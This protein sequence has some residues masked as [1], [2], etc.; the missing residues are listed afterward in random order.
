MTQQLLKAGS[1]F[2]FE[3]DLYQDTGYLFTS[4]DLGMVAILVL[5]KDWEGWLDGQETRVFGYLQTGAFLGELIYAPENP[6][7]SMASIHYR[8]EK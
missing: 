5:S 3:G 6:D 8:K 1:I 7:V 2:E 4:K